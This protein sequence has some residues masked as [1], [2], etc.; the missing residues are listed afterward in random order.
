[1]ENQPVLNRPEWDIE[2]THPEMV[3]P[4]KESLTEV[5]DPELGLDVLQLGLIRNVSNQDDG[6][7]VTMILTTPFCPYGP[8][9]LESVRQKVES[10]TGKPT[11][12]DL[13]MEPWDFSMM[14]EGLGPE[15][16][17]Y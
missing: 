17:L 14:E 12:T 2:G 13:S 15:W 9:M 1:M 3:E 8:A 11:R 4:L 16:G 10:S 6:V 5:K 7:I